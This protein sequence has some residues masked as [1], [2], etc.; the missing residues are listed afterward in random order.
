MNGMPSCTGG[1][2]RPRTQHKRHYH[3][4][5]IW[6]KAPRSRT[7][8]LIRSIRAMKLAADRA[9][10]KARWRCQV[11][12]ELIPVTIFGSQTDAILSTTISCTHGRVEIKDHKKAHINSS[13]CQTLLSILRESAE[14]LKHVKKR[15]RRQRTGKNGEKDGKLRVSTVS[16]SDGWTAFL[17]L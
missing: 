16:R 9:A 6:L 8:H 7:A 4:L 12:P 14:S 11:F 2:F 17:T 13:I 10:N 5:D 15:L 1:H 3:S